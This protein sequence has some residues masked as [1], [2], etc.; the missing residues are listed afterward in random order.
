MAE[1]VELILVLTTFPGA[2]KAGEAARI[3]LAHKLAACCTIIPATSFYT[4][5]EKTCEEAEV[6][7]LIKTRAARYADLEKKLR[8][9][10][11][12]RCQKS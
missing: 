11:P 8:R 9:F 10:I 2:E 6:L 1:E 3:L 4:W 7:M 12:T 5:Q